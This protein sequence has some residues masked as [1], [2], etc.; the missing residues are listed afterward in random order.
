MR[1][2]WSERIKNSKDKTS[3]MSNAIAEARQSGTT[4]GQLKVRVIT[5]WEGLADLRPAWEAILQS[6]K[7]LTIFSTIEWLESWWKAF[8]KD[9]ELLAPVFYNAEDEVVGIVPLYVDTVGTRLPMRIRR[10]RFVGDGSEDSD[11][12]DLIIQAEYE[13]ACIEAFLLWLETLGSWDICELNT[14]ALDSAA[15]PVLI[16]ALKARGWS[17]RVLERPRSTI[18]LPDSWEL[19]LKQTISKKERTKINYYRNRLQKRFQVAVGKCQNAGELK[20]SLKELFELHQKRWH[21]RGGPGTFATEERCE[22][23]F[24]MA[25]AFFERGW[26]EFWFL[27]LDGRP[28]AAQYG[29]R[30][31]DAVYSLQEGFDPE[32]SGDSVGYLLRAR[33]LET[34]IGQGVRSYDFLGGEDPSK[35]RWGALT[36]SY[37][38]IHFA[39]A[40]TKASRYLALVE[41]LAGA[42]KWARGHLPPGVLG[43][44]R[45]VYNPG[46]IIHKGTPRP[47][48]EESQE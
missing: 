19:Y 28:V 23:Y 26:L 9:K 16:S 27:R 15:L 18:A 38:D 17:L 37:K 10:V 21:S 47:E 2:G 24:H 31:R 41:S 45:K 30:F 22:F 12:L 14:L 25:P 43:L 11:N 4:L 35:D 34:L 32:F 7:T 36:G 40:S 6:S 29:F 3:A 46:N 13:G 39:R 1:S 8:A 33:A 42:K 48:R 5:S 20:T 44:L